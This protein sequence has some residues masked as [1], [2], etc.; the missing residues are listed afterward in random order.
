MGRR[1]RGF[2]RLTIRRAA[3]WPF[4]FG[5][6]LIL[7]DLYQTTFISLARRSVHA[8][9]LLLAGC[10]S[11]QPAGGALPANATAPARTSSAAK[12]AVGSAVAKPGTEAAAVE[13]SGQAS[14]D[15]AQNGAKA[16]G[17]IAKAEA[18]YRSGVNNYRANRLDAARMDFDFAVDAM[19]S[20]GVDLKADG[21]VSDEFNHLLDAINTLG[22]GG[23]EAGQW[24]FS[25]KLEEAPLEAA[26]DIT[27]P[28]NPE[29][30]AKLKSELNVTS[31]LPLVINDQLR[32]ISGCSRRRRTFRGT[33]RRRCS[34][35]A[36][37][38]GLMQRVLKEEGVPQDLIYLAVA[39]SGFQP[40]VVNG[41][42]GAGGMWQ[43]MTFTGVEYGLSRNGYFDYRFDRRSPTRAYAKYIKTLYNSSATGTWR[44]RRTTGARCMCSVRCSGPAMR[45]TGSSI[46]VGDAGRDARYVPQILA[47]V[48]MAKNPERYGLDKLVPSRR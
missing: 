24:I 36:S 43:F 16:Q 25:S 18:S 33:W 38:A 22:D 39:E 30:V 4:D 11:D 2:I 46:D 10:P 27:F 7:D 48:L 41:R 42:S 15:P 1:R 31:D 45:T 13:A 44:W 26:T 5:F 14:V 34:G 29:L 3:G 37:I 28:A 19:L 23:V 6:E 40:Q 21:P 20:S 35:W 8:V 9:V 12:P 47:A 17:L 32:G